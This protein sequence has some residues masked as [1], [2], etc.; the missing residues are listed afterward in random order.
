MQHRPQVIN[1][2]HCL[3]IKAAPKATDP[4]ESLSD[5]EKLFSSFLELLP[6]DNSNSRT[7]EPIT[8]KTDSDLVSK[9]YL[10][11]GVT[12]STNKTLNLLAKEKIIHDFHF[13]KNIVLTEFENFCDKQ[14]S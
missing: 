6:S 10:L 14:K 13:R 3:G 1:V 12:Y 11:S 7:A 5:L 9:L 2:L 4:N 8:P